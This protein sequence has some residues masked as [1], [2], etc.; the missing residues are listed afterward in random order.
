MKKIIFMILFFLF[1]LPGYSVESFIKDGIY[2]KD[3]DDN[4]ILDGNYV[5]DGK[6]IDIK[7][8]LNVVD[9]L[10]YLKKEFV[11]LKTGK[12]YLLVQD[13]TKPLKLFYYDEKTQSFSTD[14]I[15]V[16]VPE[17]FKFYVLQ[18]IDI[19]DNRLLFSSTY[20]TER[21]DL[22]YV[23]IKDMYND[24][25]EHYKLNNWEKPLGFRDD[26]IF[27][28]DGYYSTTTRVF[29]EYE[30][31]LVSAKLDYRKE[32]ILGI[33]DN[34]VCIYEIETG[35][36]THTK[37]FPKRVEYYPSSIAN[38]YFMN[39][40]YIY[41]SE[42]VF[43]CSCEPWWNNHQDERHDIYIYD[44]KTFKRIKKLKT[45]TQFAVVYK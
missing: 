10:F 2:C 17:A 37:I 12:I 29:T 23:I 7:N 5:I 35:K 6:V 38:Y 21:G 4:I 19:Y 3:K 39:D 25:E 34:E 24:K 26:L 45:K 42:Y 18:I 43:L 41:I 11:D 40:E 9:G 22:N 15:K 44:R 33:I 1:F 8:L 31:K 14:Y 20:K 27:F 13:S 16:K 32:N 30:Y 28:V 36:L